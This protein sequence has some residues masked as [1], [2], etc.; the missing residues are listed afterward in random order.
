MLDDPEPTYD[1]ELVGHPGQ[2]AG[3]VGNDQQRPVIAQRGVPSARAILVGDGAWDALIG[4][5]LI[6]STIASVTRPL[7][8]GSLKPWP[9]FVVLG[10]GCLAVSALLLAASTGPDAAASCR[11]IWLPNM[12]TT[13]ACVAL[14]LAFPHLAH[15]YVVALAMMGIGC[16]VFAAFEWTAG[17][18]GS[19]R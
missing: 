15:P 5:A 7:G 12:L 14:L 4:V 8:A 11:S 16:A 9:L 13:V 2:H 17:L 10:V 6:A 3:N 19:T 18:W 1:A